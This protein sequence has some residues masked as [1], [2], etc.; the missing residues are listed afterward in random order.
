MGAMAPGSVVIDGAKGGPIMS[1]KDW[2]KFAPTGDSEWKNGRGTK[3]LARAW[4]RP[5]MPADL[6]RF[7]E[8]NQPTK[9]FVLDSAR[10]D[11]KKIDLVLTGKSGRVPVVIAI[12][13]K[14]TESFGPA[15]DEYVRSA[16]KRAIDELDVLTTALFGTTLAKT[17]RLGSLRYQLVSAVAGTLIEAKKAGAKR[18]ILVIHEFRS[19]NHKPEPFAANQRDLRAFLSRF[20]EGTGAKGSSWLAGP[21]RVAGSG[22]VPDDIPLWVGKLQTRI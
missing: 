18:A 17:P 2:R 8:A 12:E 14:S 7:L 13:A 5:S 3:E 22:P 11:R 20:A 6:Q 16:K 15:L 4:C 1:V 9:S 10:A 19:A 21:I